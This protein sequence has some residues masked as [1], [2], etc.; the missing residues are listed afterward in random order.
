MDEIKAPADVKLIPKTTKLYI[1]YF[2]GNP[3]KWKCKWNQHHVNMG[4]Q[5]GIEYSIHFLATS[6][7]IVIY[8]HVSRRR[9][10][11]W[12]REPAN[13]I[14]ELLSRYFIYIIRVVA[15]SESPPSPWATF[16]SRKRNITPSLSK[17]LLRTPSGESFQNRERR[18][19]TDAFPRGY[20]EG[21]PKIVGPIEMAQSEALLLMKHCRQ[22]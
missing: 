19:H 16:E 17:T 5:L 11:P 3:S 15:G 20:G 9:A 14:R 1:F 12:S 10:S 22:C 21:S 13:Q 8:R 4:Q 18:L 6:P 2:L 7:P